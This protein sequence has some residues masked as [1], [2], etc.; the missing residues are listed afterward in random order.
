MVSLP[1]VIECSPYSGWKQPAVSAAMANTGRR[2]AKRRTGSDHDIDDPLWDDNDLLRALSVER[3]FYRIER[4][5]GS[6]DRLFSRVAVDRYIGAFLAVDL[7]GQGNGAFDQQIGLELRPALSRGHRRMAERRP[8]LL[9]QMRHHR[10][11]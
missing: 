11:E 10:A 6:L 8:A 1:P 3:L 2:R 4:Q 7:N 9:G 5:N